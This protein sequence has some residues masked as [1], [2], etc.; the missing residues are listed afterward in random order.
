MN[1]EK[2]LNNNFVIGFNDF[3][4]ETILMGKGIGF[5]LKEGDNIDDTKIEKC[6]WLS[7]STIRRYEAIVQNVSYDNMMLAEEVIRYAKEK[8]GLKLSEVIYITL[9]DH[10]NLAI[11]RHKNNSDFK[12]DLL[13]EIEEK[14]PKEFQIGIKG[15]E[16]IKEYLKME[17]L[18]DEAAFIAM[19]IV[20]TEIE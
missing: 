6:F 16:L 17:L 11:E 13:L 3:H 10:L 20:N 12:N 7:N 14:Y 9:T 19:H 8:Q 18:K 4:K 5:G 15:L 2:V 1:V